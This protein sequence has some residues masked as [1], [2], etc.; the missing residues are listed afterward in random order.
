MR[1]DAGWPRPARRVA[2]LVLR[3]SAR[4]ACLAWLAVC[5][6][7]ISAALRDGQAFAR[8]PALPGWSHTRTTGRQ[9]M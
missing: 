8:P 5:Q 9:C 4:A 1:A 2:E 6:R 7:R 3:R